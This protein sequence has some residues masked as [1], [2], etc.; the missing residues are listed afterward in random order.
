MADEDNYIK[1]FV[2]WGEYAGNVLNVTE[3]LKIWKKWHY[4]WLN[5][6]TNLNF[7]HPLK[8]NEETV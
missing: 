1:L 6:Y 4:C 3:I 5:L 7:S 8:Q 2:I